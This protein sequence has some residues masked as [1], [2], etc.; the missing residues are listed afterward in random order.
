MIEI[1]VDLWKYLRCRK[2]IWLAPVIL[3]LL[4]LGVLIFSSSGTAIAPFV[5]TVF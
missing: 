1:V 3:M 2:K 5:Y 4:L